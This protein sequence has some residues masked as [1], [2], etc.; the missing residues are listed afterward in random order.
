MKQLRQK[1]ARIAEELILFCYKFYADKINLNIEN[2]KKS[3][4]IIIEAHGLKLSDETIFNIKKLLNIPRTLEMEEYYWN[5]T[6]QSD[7]DSELSIIGAM[8]D[9]AEVNYIKESEILRIELI[10]NE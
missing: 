1:S 7:I 10:R 5:L 4:K 9:S 2:N 6:G 8:T 3:T